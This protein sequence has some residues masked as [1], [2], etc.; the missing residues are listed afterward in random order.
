MH[1]LPLFSTS[2]YFFILK[3]LKSFDDSVIQ[4]TFFSTYY[5]LRE[6]IL[7]SD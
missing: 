4:N 6:S 7:F 2:T 1:N 3:K 5:G